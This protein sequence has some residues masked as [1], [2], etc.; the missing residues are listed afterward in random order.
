[1]VGPIS[2]EERD[3]FAWKLKA[4]FILLVGL[5]AGLITLQ[6]DAGLVWFLVATVAGGIVGVILVWI[7]FPERQQLVDSE[8]VDD[9]HDWGR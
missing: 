7:A 2:D 9:D 6:A 3:A 5:S 1:M 8:G 4:G